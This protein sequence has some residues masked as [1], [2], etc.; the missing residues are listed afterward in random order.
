MRFGHF[1]V[2]C[3]KKGTLFTQTDFPPFKSYGV[4]GWWLD[5]LLKAG[6]LDRE[7]YLRFGSSSY[8]RLPEATGRQV[9]PLSGWSTTWPGVQK[10]SL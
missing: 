3:E 4:E 7:V 5:N 6:K 1:Y 10:A 2:V 8:R 9:V